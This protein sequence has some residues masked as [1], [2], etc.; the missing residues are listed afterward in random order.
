MGKKTVFVTGGT[1]NHTGAMATLLLNLRETN[2]HLADEVVIYH[3][4]ISKKDMKLMSHIMPIHFIKYTYPKSKKGFSDTIRNY[5]TEMVFCKYE[6][7]N[8]LKYYD[9]VIWSDYDV[10]IKG[11]LSELKTINGIGML[12][13]KRPL[14]M[15]LQQGFNPEKYSKY[16]LEAP[17]L[18]SALIVLHN[19]PIAKKIYDLCLEYTSKFASDLYLPEQAVFNLVFQELAIKPYSINSQGNQ[20]Y[21]YHPTNSADILP[22]D[23]IKI[24]HCYGQPK[25]WNGLDF[26]PWNCF[27]SEWLNMGGSACKERS[28]QAIHRRLLHFI[29][30]FLSLLLK[31]FF[32]K[33][34]F[35]KISQ[36][37]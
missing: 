23:L 10:Y 32:R 27:Y 35:S 6:C 29:I 22:D 14:R 36:K 37:K 9:T 19:V 17:D 30:F 33:T 31:I 21:T 4:G 7:F 24:Y 5:F 3:D 25:F 12:Y 11:N 8:L 2:P 34:Y 13:A 16:N 18:S 20:A 28:P 1:A 15:I 26:P